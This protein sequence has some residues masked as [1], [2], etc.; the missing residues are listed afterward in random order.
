M[1]L[2][3][4]YFY[5]KN[6]RK[7]ADIIVEKYNKYP[8]HVI[9]EKSRKYADKINMSEFEFEEF[10]R[11]LEKD[12]AKDNPND[13]LKPMTSIMKALGDTQYDIKKRIKIK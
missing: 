12:L 1:Y 13:D 10:T 8:Y 7:F 9:L 6:A 11:I 4:T 2:E 5:K 3:K